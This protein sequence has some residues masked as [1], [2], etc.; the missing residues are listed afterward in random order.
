MRADLFAI[1]R[2]DV[3]RIIR[4]SEPVVDP[5][6]R[7][8]LAFAWG[9]MCTHD[10][11]FVRHCEIVEWM[12]GIP[13]VLLGPVA[14]EL[15]NH[16]GKQSGCRRRPRRMNPVAALERE[17]YLAVVLD[18]YSRRIV[19]WSMATTLATQLVLD[20]LNMALLMGW[21]F[22]PALAA[23]VDFIDL[24]DAL[25]HVPVLLH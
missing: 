23:K 13:E 15:A 12:R 11:C 9:T 5:L 24:D 20:V 8:I 16:L 6:A 25:E 17:I 18:A 14:S 19:S 10:A 1:R 4:I 7:W 2:P 21:S 22:L 3:Q